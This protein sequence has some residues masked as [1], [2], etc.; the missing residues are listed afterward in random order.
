MTADGL[1][2]RVL[3]ATRN[4][5][6]YLP[7]QLDS[8]VAQSHADW[9]LDVGDDGSTDGT[10]G[11]VARFAA[12]Q[13]PRPVRLEPGPQAGSAAN[14]LTL[15]ARAHQAEPEAALAFC[16]QDDVWLPGKL[17]RA[18]AWLTGNGAGQ[19]APLAWVCRTVLTDADLVPQG[20]SRVFPR[21]PAFGNALVQNILAGNT[22]VLSPA[23]AAAVA[24]TVPAALEAG[25]PYHDW[26]VYQV[27]TGIGG[28]IGMEPEPLV[29]YRQH[30]SN[31]LGHH[32]PV[33]GRLMRLGIVARRDYSG[34]LDANLAA[35]RASRHLLTPEA[36]RQLRG[37]AMAR[38]RGGRALAA[39]LPR[40][41]LY[42]QSPR[43]D[44]MLRLMAL[45]ERL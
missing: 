9:S 22:I 8:L 12:E 25:V 45:A 32:G 26:W 34:W 40:L 19:G 18:A 39:A 24:Q 11:L 27:I 30:Q 23:A 44:R 16:D 37:F 2:I 15:L 13:R 17:A 6:A 3:L 4:G 14:F 21:P 7:G 42:R 33:R 10:I 28:Q 35:L 20:E 5:A 41:G 31:H 1:H 43:G 36:R 29:L 38:T